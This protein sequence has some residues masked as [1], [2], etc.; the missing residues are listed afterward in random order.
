MIKIVIVYSE[1]EDGLQTFTLLYKS[2]EKKA[3]FDA[4]GFAYKLNALE[5]KFEQLDQLP[6]MQDDPSTRRFLRS[7][8]FL[9]GCEATLKACTCHGEVYKDEDFFDYVANHVGGLFLV[10]NCRKF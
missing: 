9:F 7:P 1:T 5:E 6:R 2:L 3:A 8:V 10:C 4:I